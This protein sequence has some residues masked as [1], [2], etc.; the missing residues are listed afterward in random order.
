MDES[1]PK[2]SM[3]GV[4]DFFNKVV[5]FIF[6][7][8]L[9]VVICIIVGT[10]YLGLDVFNSSQ[11]GEELKN[12]STIVACG[13]ILIG[14]FYSIINYEHNQI[15]FNTEAKRAKDTFS[16]TTACEWYSP[17]MVDNLKTTRMLYNE[18][19]HLIDDNKAIEF[20]KILDENE[21]ARSALVSIFNCLECVAIGINNGILDETI[22]KIYLK[23]IYIDHSMD[24]SFYIDYR[25]NV[26]KK[27]QIW[28]NFTTLA[29]RWK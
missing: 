1:T 27:P 23:S 4:E 2:Y 16:Y 7:F 22:L 25:R 20:S 26:Q 3:K 17:S 13:S 8:R 10:I 5:R 21:Q 29:N 24:Y 11:N 9:V 14:I 12:L 28:E 15:K 18:N 19:K 6:Y